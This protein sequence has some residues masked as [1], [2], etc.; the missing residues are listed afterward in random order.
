MLVQH[1]KNSL[2]L[3]ISPPYSRKKDINM[4][5]CHFSQVCNL[6]SVKYSNKKIG[7]FT[8]CVVAIVFCFNLHPKLLYGFFGFVNL[9]SE[10]TRYVIQIV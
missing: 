8:C 10:F 3:F 2:W 5:F 4:F 6:K 7:K 1:S 9:N